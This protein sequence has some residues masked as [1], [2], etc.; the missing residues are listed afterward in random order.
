MYLVSFVIEPVSIE[1]FPS[2]CGSSYEWQVYRS[3]EHFL[4]VLQSLASRLTDMPLPSYDPSGG[5]DHPFDISQ[6]CAFF[7]SYGSKQPKLLFWGDV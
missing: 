5:D 1:L 6:V 2:F 4:E 7:I 3:P